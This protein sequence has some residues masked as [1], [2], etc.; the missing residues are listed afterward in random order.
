MKMFQVLSLIYIYK[1]EKDMA[2]PFEEYA[3]PLKFMSISFL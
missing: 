1:K 2:Y 3:L